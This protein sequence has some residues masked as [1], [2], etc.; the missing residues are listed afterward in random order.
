MPIEECDTN[1]ARH[2]ILITA[3]VKQ[4]LQKRALLAANMHEANDVL[5]RH[6]SVIPRT[7]SLPSLVLVLISLFSDDAD[8]ELERAQ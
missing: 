2:W 4:H 5:D 6:A 3:S 8:V 1:A 7:L